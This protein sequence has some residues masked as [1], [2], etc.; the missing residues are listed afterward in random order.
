MLLFVLL[1]PSLTIDVTPLKPIV[2]Y[3]N[4]LIMWNN[5]AEI[6]IYQKILQVWNINSERNNDIL[7]KDVEILKK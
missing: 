3:Q 5:N 4:I 2:I 1:T 7:E 6:V